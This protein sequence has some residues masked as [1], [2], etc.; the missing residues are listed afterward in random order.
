MTTDPIADMLT[1]IRNAQAVKKEFIEVPFSG[2]KFKIARLL[3]RKKAVDSVK[4]VKAKN[5]K[6]IK[7]FLKYENGK[8]AI[9]GLKRISKPGQRIYKKAKEI[10]KVKGGFGFA[11]ISTPKGVLTDEEA[12]REKVGGELICEIW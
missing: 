5:Y 7:I 2:V 9:E 6:I 11:I 3:E 12:R 8:P 4:L 1:R 10:K